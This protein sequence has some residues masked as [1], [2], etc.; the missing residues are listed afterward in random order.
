MVKLS[1][2]P[3]H[4]FFLLFRFSGSDSLCG[5]ENAGF[6]AEKSPAFHFAV[7]QIKGLLQNSFMNE[8]LGNRAVCVWS[9]ASELAHDECGTPA[10]RSDERS[11]PVKDF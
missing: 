1:K 10:C 9:S 11:I 5:R 7:A 3:W 4:S 2:L 8:Q 6:V